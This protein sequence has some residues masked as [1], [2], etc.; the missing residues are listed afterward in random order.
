[1][2]RLLPHCAIAWPNSF[3]I[4]LVYQTN[5]TFSHI[6]R[7][8]EVSNKTLIWLHSPFWTVE[9]QSSLDKYSSQIW[10]TPELEKILKSW[11]ACEAYHQGQ[12]LSHELY[13]SAESQRQVLLHQ[14]Q[15]PSTFYYTNLEAGLCLL[16]CS[17]SYWSILFPFGR[18]YIRFS[19]KR[20]PVPEIWRL[21]IWD[22]RE[23]E[24]EDIT[25]R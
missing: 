22:L 12:G 8:L 14:E 2:T 18:I 13:L 7:G 17:Y 23:R 16:K 20:V 10:S 15:I 5:S 25:C 24:R 11:L 6:R 21:T 3:Y 9:N 4:L 19:D 1:M